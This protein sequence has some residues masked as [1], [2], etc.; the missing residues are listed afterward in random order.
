M[1]LINGIESNALKH[2]QTLFFAAGFG[3]EKAMNG[4]ARFTKASLK[5]SSLLWPWTNCTHVT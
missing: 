4:R 1:K 2:E 3:S 5:N